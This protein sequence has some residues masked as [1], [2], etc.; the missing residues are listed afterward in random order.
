MARRFRLEEAVAAVQLSESENDLSDDVSEE[1]DEIEFEQDSQDEYSSSELESEGQSSLS[2]SEVSPAPRRRKKA[3][4]QP[5]SPSP[6]PPVTLVGVN[7]HTWSTD[8][9]HTGRAVQANI[10]R[11][12]SGVNPSAGLLQA[13]ADSFNLFLTEDM[14]LLVVRETNRHG[15]QAARDWN[16]ANVEGER[17]V[18]NETDVVELR[19][20]VGL[21]LYAGAHKSGHESWNVMWS[22]KEGR[23]LYRATMSLNRAK[24]LFRHMRFD[25]VNT[26]TD[27]IRTDKLAPIRDLWEMHVA[28]LQRH[29]RPDSCITIDEQLVATRGRCSFRQYIPSKPSKYGIKIFWACDSATSYPLNGKV[30]VGRQPG[31]AVNSNNVTDLVKELSRP[32]Y[33]TG[34]NLTMDNYFTSVELAVDMLAV[35]TTVVGTMR[36]N[37]RDIPKELLP[38]RAKEQFS[39]IFCFDDQLTLTSYV[40]K[41]SKAVILLSTMHHDDTVDPEND[42]KPEIILYYNSTKSGVDNFDHLVGQYTCKR[43]T[44]RW[45]MTLFYNIIDTS[46]VAAYV[47]WCCKHPEYNSGKTHKRRLFLVELAESLI[48]EQLIRRMSN[49]QAMQSGVKLA[50]SALGYDQQRNTP[51]AAPLPGKKR[52]VVC[53]RTID[54]KTNV[55]CRECGHPCC[56]EHSVVTCQLCN[57]NN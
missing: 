20:F 6:P 22:A 34:R 43:K 16:E 40:P 19:A 35:R 17:R 38:S 53:P 57:D 7:G 41:K 11:Q 9:P 21:L 29:Y 12:T 31:A 1:E 37:R 23:P 24:E 47:V 44:R 8:R 18:W 52:C 3:R 55:R 32:W 56:Q 30:Y 2:D 48:Q 54:R 36:K 45:P 28:T 26:R 25:N 49:P 4:F 14:L 27:R 42:N 39:S 51:Q 46:A 13:I 33:N 50:F 5:S 10:L 15:R